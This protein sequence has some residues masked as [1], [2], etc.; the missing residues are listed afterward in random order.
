MRNAPF[1]LMLAT[2][3]FMLSLTFCG[4]NNLETVESRD[5]EG[6]LERWQRNK[7]DFAKEG[8][9]QRFYPDGTMA[10][11]A[12]YI[13]DTFHGERKFFYKNGAVEITEHYSNG[14]YHG[15]Y[16]KYNEKG[17][18]IVEQ[19]YVNGAMQGFSLV[20]YP[21]GVLKEKYTI[22]D[23]EDDGPF[24]EYYENGK[25]KTEGVYVPAEDG[26]LE[27]GELKEYDET[28]QL[29]RIAHCTDG[30]CLTTWE[31]KK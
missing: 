15:K 29:I 11:E 23:N 10:E 26:S 12:H 1:S 31:L 30:K 20:Y 25:L 22:R 27:Q 5:S 24:Q 9:Y 21:N 3:L 18:L 7:T 16:L 17:N 14:V 2:G 13:R 6:R 19:E 8:L 4:D 28:G